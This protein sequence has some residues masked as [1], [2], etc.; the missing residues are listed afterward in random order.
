[1]K[2]DVEKYIAKRKRTD[3]AF[4][5]GFEA[6]YAGFKRRVKQFPGISFR[7]SRSGHEAF[8]TGH[9]VAVWEVVRV[10][11]ETKTVAKTAAYFRWTPALVRTALAY[12]KAFPAEIAGHDKGEAG[13][14]FNDLLASVK[15]AKAIMR[16]E[17][18]PGRVS[19]VPNAA[20]V[21]TIKASQAGKGVK[22]FGSKKADLGV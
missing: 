7:D 12:A 5:K 19:L 14:L 10:K 8:L 22:R 2:N 15:E 17:L 13:T 4:A 3:K 1:M 21:R 16:G 18:K 6:G 20:T 11:R 9:R